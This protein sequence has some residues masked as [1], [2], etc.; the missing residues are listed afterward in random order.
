M[1]WWRHAGRF[2]SLA[3]KITALGQAPT[4]ATTEEHDIF[5]FAGAGGE[6]GSLLQALVDQ[7]N[8]LIADWH[9]IG[10]KLDQDATVAA[11]DFQAQFTAKQISFV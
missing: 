2:S 7:H 3:R 6:K 5:L 8:Q 9:L 4:P 1:R 10:D 11:V